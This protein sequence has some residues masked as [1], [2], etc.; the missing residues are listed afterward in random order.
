MI[1]KRE[2]I[3]LFNLEIMDSFFLDIHCFFR[4]FNLML[5][6]IQFEN[7]IKYNDIHLEYERELNALP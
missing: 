7:A 2:V 3:I 1:E 4:F 5:G 6:F